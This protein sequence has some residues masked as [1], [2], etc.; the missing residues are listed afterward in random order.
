MTESNLN[1]IL[2]LSSRA[3]GHL[4]NSTAE[5]LTKAKSLITQIQ[6]VVLDSQ[7]VTN[8]PIDTNTAP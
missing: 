5:D 7:K 2:D 3:L 4:Y 1:L 8:T 6:R